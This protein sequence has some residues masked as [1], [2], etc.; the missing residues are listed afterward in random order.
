[1]SYG[2][3]KMVDGAWRLESKSTTENHLGVFAG[4]E[5]ETVNVLRKEQEEIFEE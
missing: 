1:V 4:F 3:W 5:R 2:K